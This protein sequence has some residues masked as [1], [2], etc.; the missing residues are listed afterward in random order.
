MTPVSNSEARKRT[1]T[2]P[3]GDPVDGLRA[4]AKEIL[5]SCEVPSSWLAGVSNRIY[6][7]T[8][9]VVPR[10][11]TVSEIIAHLDAGG[12]VERFKG[13][14]WVPDVANSWMWWRQ[15]AS[16]PDYAVPDRRLVPILV[17]TTE[18]VPLHR[19][20]GRTLPGQE[21]EVTDIHVERED[22]DGVVTAWGRLLALGHREV[23]IPVATDGT[24]EVL[25]EDES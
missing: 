13:G 14:E 4:L 5:E 15:L 1:E 17:P 9:Q 25:V 3:S 20:P 11:P 22:R 18:R 24:V 10:P 19:V 2:R 16:S 6:A 23:R 21:H 7:L 8:G 12:E